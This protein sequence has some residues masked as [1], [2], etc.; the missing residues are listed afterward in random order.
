MRIY[1][2]A[3]NINLPHSTK[4]LKNSGKSISKSKLRQGDVL[5]FGNFFGVNHAGIYINN[6]KFLHASSLKGVTYAELESD[7]FQKR[8]KGARRYIK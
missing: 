2:D 4:E 1:K 6:G 5:L 8:Y 7:Y 3:F